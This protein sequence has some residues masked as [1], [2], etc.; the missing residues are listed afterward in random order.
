MRREQSLWCVALALV[1]S[2]LWASVSAA[3]EVDKPL[4]SFPLRYRGAGRFRHAEIPSFQLVAR[5]TFDMEAGVNREVATFIDR[6]IEIFNVYD[7]DPSDGVDP[8]R[9]YFIERD[10][11]TGELHCT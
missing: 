5:Y 3:V 1:V 9:E 7:M 11:Q 4:P 2:L 8:D 10:Q 6:E